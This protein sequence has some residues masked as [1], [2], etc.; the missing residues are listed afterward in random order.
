[1]LNVRGII[2]GNSD[3]SLNIDFLDW[4]LLIDLALIII[5]LIGTREVYMH[6]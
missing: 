3:Y 6:L 2:S 1:M 5:A 4:R